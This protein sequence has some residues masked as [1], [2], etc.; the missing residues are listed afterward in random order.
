MKKNYTGYMTGYEKSSRD[1]P[2]HAGT[3]K[4]KLL[5][6]MKERTNR[7]IKYNLKKNKNHTHRKNYS[8]PS[9]KMEASK[10]NDWSHGKSKITSRSGT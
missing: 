6:E 1:P 4:K 7:G 5:S 10:R 2:L 8:K 9:S 3:K